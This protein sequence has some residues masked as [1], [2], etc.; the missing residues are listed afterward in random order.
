MSDVSLIIKV[1]ND[2]MSFFMKKKIYLLVWTILIPLLSGLAYWGNHY[3]SGTIYSILLS[4]FLVGTQI[5]KPKKDE[6]T[7]EN[8]ATKRQ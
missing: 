6:T 8:M 3:F 2:I 4:L 7:P 1:A 5:I